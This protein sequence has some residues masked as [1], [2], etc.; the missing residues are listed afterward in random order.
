[1]L[2]EPG[3]K[4]LLSANS[5]LLSPCLHWPS[6][7]VAL[8]AINMTSLVTCCQAWR[9]AEWRSSEEQEWGARSEE[10]DLC[11]IIR[12]QSSRSSA[13]FAAPQDVYLLTGSAHISSWPCSSLFPRL[14]SETL[15][16]CRESRGDGSVAGNQ[17]WK[18]GKSSKG[19][20]E[21]REIL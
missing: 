8:P 7:S 4:S 2:L 17:G 11:K 14:I 12:V 10:R 15:D 1:M 9:R 13:H 18:H 21:E 16:W 3:T 19:S 6:A 5:F 20:E